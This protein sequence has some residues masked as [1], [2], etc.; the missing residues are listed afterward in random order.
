MDKAA[1][2]NA[3]STQLKDLPRG[4]RRRVLE[5]YDELIRDATEEG[6]T[7]AQVLSELDSPQAIA[8]R[9]LSEL[10]QKPPRNV[11]RVLLM[12]LGAPFA[13][14]FGG[15]ALAVLA[16]VFA[17]L[18]GA[19]A[20]IYG[21]AV[22]LL[23]RPWLTLAYIVTYSQPATSLAIAPLALGLGLLLLAGALVLTPLLARLTRT[24]FVG[25]FEFALGAFGK[26]KHAKKE[27]T[28]HA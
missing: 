27:E 10:P 28:C 9:I 6:K 24:A 2:L 17:G 12:I 13:L 7:Q 18:W 3:L 15:V 11:A 1:F 20:G 23:A 25:L 4:E 21:G 19:L 16:G 14:L 26:R 8:H 22:G 5:Y